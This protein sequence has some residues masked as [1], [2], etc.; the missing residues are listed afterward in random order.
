MTLAVPQADS[1][2][3]ERF[4]LE[5][6]FCYRRHSPISV[7]LSNFLKN[8]EQPTGRSFSRRFGSLEVGGAIL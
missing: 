4:R 6:A 5:V 7:F 3:L 8:N 1:V 2:L